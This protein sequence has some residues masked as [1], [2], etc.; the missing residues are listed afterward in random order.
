M[1]EEVGHTIKAHTFGGV[2]RKHNG[3]GPRK[4]IMIVAPAKQPEKLKIS[5]LPYWLFI[6]ALRI[7]QVVPSTS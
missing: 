5:L 6:M 3:A 4:I 2:E 1:A 7:T